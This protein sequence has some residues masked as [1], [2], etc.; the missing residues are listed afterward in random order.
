MLSV[1][2]FQFAGALGTAASA[3][4]TIL[5]VLITARY[6]EQTRELVEETRR[7][8]KQ[9]EA[10]REEAN[11]REV[12]SLRIALRQEIAGIEGYRELAQSY[13]TTRSVLDLDVPTTIYESNA[14][15]IGLLS[16]PEI[17][18]IVE[19]YA[20]VDQVQSLLELQR[21]AD[22]PINM[23][24]LT[25]FWVRIQ[26][27]T[28]FVAYKITFG[29]FGSLGQ[30][31]REEAIREKFEDIAVAQDEAIKEIDKRL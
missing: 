12:R 28:D 6:V 22:V 11:K 26:A 20:Q 24:P 1:Q 7:Q 27:I 19:Y 23:D 14:D 16:E 3:F 10:A 13:E 17:S 31:V 29:R 15:D 4:I 18:A 21:T 9:E 25:D 8:R 2:R 5:L 30:K